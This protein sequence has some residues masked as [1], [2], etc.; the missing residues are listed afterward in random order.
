MNRIFLLIPLFVFSIGTAYAEPLENIQ[1]SV[2]DY[3]DY[4]ATVQLDWNN[5]EMVKKYEIGCVSCIPNVVQFSIEDN[6]TLKN[7]T[8]FTNSS[9]AMLYIIAYDSDNEI[10]NAKQVILELH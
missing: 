9:Y 1:T 2:L 4:S 3:D 8:A 10:I 6:F 7:V 5:D